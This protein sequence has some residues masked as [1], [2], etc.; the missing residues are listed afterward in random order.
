MPKQ[1]LEN[2]R[3][4]STTV[5]AR[6]PS[7]GVARIE[8]SSRYPCVSRHRVTAYIDHHLS[9]RWPQHSML[10]DECRR[11]L[12]VGEASRSR[13]MHNTDR[14]VAMNLKV[15]MR[16]IKSVSVPNQTNLLASSNRLTLGYKD[17]VQVRVQR[18]SVLKLTAFVE[19]MTNHNHIA[20][21]TFEISG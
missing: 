16:V 7:N 14:S 4:A 3:P 13:G 5:A 11:I 15:Q 6:D 2:R 18:I 1:R 19:R 20:P 17:F 10:H 8:R 12:I 21:R 9:A